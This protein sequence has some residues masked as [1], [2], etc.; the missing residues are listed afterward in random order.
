ML[1][2]CESFALERGLR[3]NASKTQL[4]R[5]SFHSPLRVLLI[6]HLCGYELP[7]LDSVV[8]LGHLLSYNLCD[9]P[10]VNSKLRDI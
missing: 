9:T 8:H 10:D 5:F 1:Q 4:I 7:F 6:F 3:F 2:W